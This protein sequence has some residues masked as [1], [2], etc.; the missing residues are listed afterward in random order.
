LP[1]SRTNSIILVKI[2]ISKCCKADWAVST[3]F[4]LLKNLKHDF[5]KRKIKKPIGICAVCW[6]TR[7]ISAGT[8]CWMTLV[9]AWLSL[10]VILAVFTL[11]RLCRKNY[12]EAPQHIQTNYY[13][14]RALKI[15]KMSQH[16]FPSVFVLF[17]ITYWIFY[18]L[19]PG[20][21]GMTGH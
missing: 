10:S 4:L 18:T 20:V 16:V 14:K 21:T 11:Q 17:V 5:T 15:D 1:N 12:H 19:P 13:K 8:W 7:P 3:V 6:C 2:Y 9:S